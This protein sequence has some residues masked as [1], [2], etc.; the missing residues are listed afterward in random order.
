[1]PKTD[2]TQTNLSPSGNIMGAGMAAGHIKRGYDLF[3][4][5]DARGAVSEFRQAIELDPGSSETYGYLGKAYEELGQWNEALQVYLQLVRL[6]PNDAKS[7]YFLGIAY[8]NLG[9]WD[10]AVKS[11][12]EA[13]RLTPK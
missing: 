10:K 13:L 5:G 7:H 3:K 9:R 2:S 12:E 6:T 1:M 11:F 4:G 8:K